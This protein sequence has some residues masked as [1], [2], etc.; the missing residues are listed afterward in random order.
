ME[1]QYGQDRKLKKLEE[2]YRAIDKKIEKLYQKHIKGWLEISQTKS[3]PNYYHCYYDCKRGKTVRKYIKKKDM[4]IAKTLARNVYYKKLKALLAARLPMLER[5]NESYREDEI[6]SLYDDLSPMRQALFEPVSMTKKGRLSKW[7]EQPYSGN[8]MTKSSAEIVTNRLEI[9][10]SKSE[11]ILADMFNAANVPYKY[12]CP[13]QIR[14]GY[15]I[16]PDFTFLDPVT[17][18]EIYWEHFG[19]MDDEEYSN[20]ALEKIKIYEA[21]GLYM[22]ERLLVSFESSQVFLNLESVRHIIENRLRWPE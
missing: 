13:L 11:K 3:G 14:N 2:K 22:G 1:R 17:L 19:L 7:L 5:L 18:E 8:P 9:V 6:D 20:R 16:Y 21:A 10:R 4:E 15:V 12:E